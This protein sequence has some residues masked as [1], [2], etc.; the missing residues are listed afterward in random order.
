MLWV[1]VL[2]ISIVNTTTHKTMGQFNLLDECQKA[3]VVAKQEN[4][5]VVGRCELRPAPKQKSI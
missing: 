4:K 1:W 2:S 5:N 3:L